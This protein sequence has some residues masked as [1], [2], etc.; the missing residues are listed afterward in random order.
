MNFIGSSRWKIFVDQLSNL[1]PFE[2]SVV[3][4]SSLLFNTDLLSEVCLL[5]VA[6]SQ[7]CRHHH[8]QFFILRETL[9]MLLIWV[10]R[11]SSDL[12]A[13]ISLIHSK[14]SVGFFS[15]EQTSVRKFTMQLCNPYG[16][17]IFRDACPRK[18]T[19]PAEIIT[20][21]NIKL[22][23]KKKR[24]AWSYEYYGFR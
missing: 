2:K 15:F 11:S 23:L 19:T 5:I 14:V 24:S 6:P 16:L 22:I 1:S 20:D 3:L 7:C 18:D 9:Y 13:S 4:L 12:A 21:V 10:T 17:G 8:I